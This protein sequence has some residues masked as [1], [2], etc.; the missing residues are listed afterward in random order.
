MAELA[1]L[2]SL[3]L[4]GHPATNREMGQADSLAPGWRQPKLDSAPLRRVVDAVE[5]VV[6]D[7]SIDERRSGALRDTEVLRE[8]GQADARVPSDIE[9]DP[10][11]RDGQLASP[12]RSHLASD[13]AHRPRDDIE[14]PLGQGLDGC[15]VGGGADLD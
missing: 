6:A 5:Q 15:A 14:D 12:S 11:L 8:G 2:D 1:R 7:E 4:L 13:S 9:Q 10:E 3:Q